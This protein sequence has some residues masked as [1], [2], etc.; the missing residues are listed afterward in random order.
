MKTTERWIR[1]A[2]N[3]RSNRCECGKV[4]ITK[5]PKDYLKYRLYIAGRRIDSFKTLRDALKYLSSL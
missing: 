2:R 3:R 1:D 4:T 5:R